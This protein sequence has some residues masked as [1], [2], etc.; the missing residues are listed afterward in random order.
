MATAVRV[1][2]YVTCIRTVS[3]GD[4]AS[5]MRQFVGISADAFCHRQI[6]EMVAKRTKPRYHCQETLSA[7]MLSGSVSVA[8]TGKPTRG[9]RVDSSTAP[10]SS[11]LVTLTITACSSVLP[12]VSVTTT[13]TSY[14]LFAPESP[15]DS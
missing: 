1:S 15:G 4:A 8:V 9:C 13:V 12:F 10:S 7:V 3:A 5:L 6:S 11:M 14:T 2:S